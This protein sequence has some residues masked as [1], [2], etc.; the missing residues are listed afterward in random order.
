MVDGSLHYLAPHSD[1][2]L[3]LVELLGTFSSKNVNMVFCGPMQL[4]GSG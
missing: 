4:V 3:E 1:F 2:E